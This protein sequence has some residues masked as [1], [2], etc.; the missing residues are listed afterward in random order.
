MNALQDWVINLPLMQQS[1]L[2][3]AIRGPDGVAKKHK[4]KPLVRWFRR[5]VLVSAFDGAAI[6]DPRATQVEDRLPGRRS[7]NT[8]ISPGRS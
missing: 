3:S 8:A 2:I 4:C 5:C 7:Q 1:V 6:T